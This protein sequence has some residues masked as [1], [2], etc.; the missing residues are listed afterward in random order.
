[1]MQRQDLSDES[2]DEA[3]DSPLLQV[4]A[5]GLP[6]ARPDQ[7]GHNSR[8]SWTDTTPSSRRPPKAGPGLSLKQQASSP[9]WSVRRGVGTA[10]ISPASALRQGTG[11][12]SGQSRRSSQLGLPVRSRRALSQDEPDHAA[13]DTWPLHRAQSVMVPKSQQPDLDK[14]FIEL[15]ELESLGEK[16][17]DRQLHESAPDRVASLE[18]LP[19]WRDEA[20]EVHQAHVQ[21]QPGEALDASY[22][23]GDWADAMQQ[24]Q[25]EDPKQRLLQ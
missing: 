13:A 15:S 24:E 10:L 16:A 5:S 2:D 19:S 17:G 25:T 23:Y 20:Q 7:T 21:E 11:T 1:M 22:D 3:G 12:V 8:L 6:A 4:P 14:P 18:S 9:R